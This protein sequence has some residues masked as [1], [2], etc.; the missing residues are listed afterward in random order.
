MSREEQNKH[1]SPM[2][3]ASRQP[4]HVCFLTWPEEFREALAPVE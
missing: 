1:E 3:N 2:G 4:E